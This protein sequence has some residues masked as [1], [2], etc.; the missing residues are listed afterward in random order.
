MTRYGQIQE[1]RAEN[2]SITAYF[3]RVEM[4]FTA[5]DIAD[6][7]QVPVLLSSIGAK[8]YELLR[9]LVAPKVPKE[10]TFKDIEKL[11]KD[12]F[13]P[14]PSVI[15]ERYRFHRR[16]Q[17]VGENITDY[18]AE[19]RKLTT[20]CKFEETTDFLEESLRDRFVCGLRSEGTRKRLLTENKLTFSKALEIAQSL[21]A[22]TKDAQLK[23]SDQAPN[24][25]GTV[26]KVKSPP[27]KKTP[28]A[29]Y[30]CGLTNHK[31]ADCRLKDATCHKCGRKG[32][33]QRA[34]R[35][36]GQPQKGGK[37][38]PR[39]R[40]KTKWVNAEPSEDDS[41]GSANVCTIGKP[42]TRPIRVELQVNC[43]PLA[44]E[45]DTGAAVSLISYK[46]LK[47]VLP[48][49]SINKTTVVLRTYTSEVIP[50]RG[51]V[52][53]N[54]QYGNQNKKLTLY[55]T[56]NEGPCLMGR[57]WLRSIRLDWC[58]IGLTLVDTTQ[59]QLATLLKR[60]E[61]VFR[62]ELGTISLSKPSLSCERT[63]HPSFTG[64]APSPS[65]SR[66]RLKRSSND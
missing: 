66:E 16:D 48:R 43:K 51:E 3:E 11:L 46:R 44:M 26:H 34:C 53:V 1:F 32:H 24:G 13:E 62:D 40:E 61:E 14:T 65:H 39:R 36:G 12:H 50:V 31:A 49:I 4:Y 54:V 41:D 20:H 10:K 23:F 17:A 33:I 8:T 15:A 45:V 21:E 9:S 38:M 30:R 19:L 56:R 42:S 7:K 55:V 58:T 64:P 37:F 22:A 59:T 5:N 57:D 35:S 18:V 6:D 52:L 28:E 47:R 63:P 27:P 60:H 25:P 29:C 2:D